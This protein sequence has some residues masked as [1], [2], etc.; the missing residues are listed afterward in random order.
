[1]TLP[2]LQALITR[3][4]LLTNDE[5]AYWLGTLGTMQPQ[6]LQKLE[7]ILTEAETIPL[8]ESVH[9]YFQAIAK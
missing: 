3:S 6:Q 5:R 1:M 9:E 7:A 8:K 2:E 4:E